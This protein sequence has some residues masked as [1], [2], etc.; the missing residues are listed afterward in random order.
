MEMKCDYL[1]GSMPLAEK[2][3]IARAIMAEAI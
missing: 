2:V 1:C 3:V